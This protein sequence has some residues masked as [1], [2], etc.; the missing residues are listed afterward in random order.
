ML[1]TVIFELN[2]SDML[3]K[4]KKFKLSIVTPFFNEEESLDHFFTNITPHLNSISNDWEIICIDDGSSDNTLSL[5]KE[6]AAKNSKIK[7][8]SFSRNFGKEAALTAGLEFASGDAIIP[9]DADL[10]DPPELIGQMVSKWLSGSE[11]VLAMRSSRHDNFIKNL[12]S[13]SYHLLISKLTRGHI[14]ARVGDFR[15]M[16]RKV[17]E[18]LKLLPE[19]S[20]YMK[21]LFAWVGFKQSV[22]TYVRPQRAIGQASQSFTKLW[23]L[24]LDGI[25]AFSSL[26]LKIWL[27]VGLI[28]SG[29]SFLYAL[30]IIIKT[31]ILGIDLP[32]YASLMVAT[33]FMGGMN[34]LSL[35]ILGEYV[36]RIYKEVKNRPIYLLRE[37]YGFQKQSKRTVKTS[38]KATKQAKISV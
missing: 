8:L 26:P 27:Y 7:V 36:A 23:K 35:G 33:L 37:K 30:F 28:F 22:V 32:G 21:G 14:P 24:A 19:K 4:N 11:V 12:L 6:R 34:L 17:V 3:A 9:I 25:F 2:I 20:R 31:L 29:F 16:D 10:Q 15:L 5:L 13:D 38:S 18:V 1:Y